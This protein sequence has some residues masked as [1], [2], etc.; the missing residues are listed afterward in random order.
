M[1]EY[2]INLDTVCWLT[3]EKVGRQ[4]AVRAEF[5][6]GERRQFIMRELDWIDLRRAL[7]RRRFKSVKE[8]LK[9]KGQQ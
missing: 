3:F 7:D 6:N 2:I 5:I 8:Q 9:S 4:V 1:R